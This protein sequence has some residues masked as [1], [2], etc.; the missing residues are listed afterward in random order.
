MLW[1][2]NDILLALC[3][4]NLK[5]FGLIDALMLEIAALHCHSLVAYYDL[6]AVDL[7]I[8]LMVF[9]MFGCALLLFIQHCL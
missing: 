7:S 5:L 8:L 2:P 3:L 6:L 9:A 1:G 4:D